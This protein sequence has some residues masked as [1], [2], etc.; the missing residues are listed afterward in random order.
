MVKLVCLNYTGFGLKLKGYISH[1]KVVEEVKTYL[2]G[3]KKNQ[4]IQFL[5]SNN[6]KI[7][8]LKIKIRVV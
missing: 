3:K 6:K 4:R 8:E 1:K 2:R 5:K 7:L